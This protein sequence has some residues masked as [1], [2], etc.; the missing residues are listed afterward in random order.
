[1][2]ASLLEGSLLMVHSKAT[3][4]GQHRLLH[5]NILFIPAANLSDLL[6]WL[7]RRGAPTEKLS[8]GKSGAIAIKSGLPAAET[9]SKLYRM[10]TNGLS[11]G[12]LVI[13]CKAWLGVLLSL[14]KLSWW[15]LEE[16]DGNMRTKID[17]GDL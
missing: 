11:E 12:L 9:F 1:M 5:S 4:R 10:K 8:S 2:K 3:L 14:V 16:M 15:H 6:A 13:S 17:H 7:F